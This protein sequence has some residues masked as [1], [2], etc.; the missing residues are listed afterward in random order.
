M[1]K[2]TTQTSHRNHLFMKHPLGRNL[3]TEEQLVT[4]KV[5]RDAEGNIIRIET[6][7]EIGKLKAF[8]LE[9]KS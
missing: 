2:P 4:T 8:I 9:D 3:D 1:N 7:N 5:E 6:R